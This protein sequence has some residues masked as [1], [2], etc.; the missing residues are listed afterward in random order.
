MTTLL[1]VGLIGAGP[2]TQAIHLPTL[3]TLSERL[4]VR[5]VMDVDDAVAHEVAG[6][7]GARASTDVQA[8][9][10]DAAVDVVGVCSPSPFHADQVTAA[11][12]AGKRAVFCEKPLATSADEA[13]RIANVA[14]DTGVPIVVGTMHAYDPAYVAAARL[15]D[16]QGHVAHLV[17]STIYLPA[18]DELVTL[19]TD[20]VAAPA[21]P[22]PHQD[23]ASREGRAARIRMA[24]LGLA[25]HTTPLVRRLLG[26][27]VAVADARVVMPLG[28]RLTLVSAGRSA[29]LVS[30]MPG[31][32]QPEWT[33]EAW[34]DRAVMRVWFPPSYVLAGSA[35]ADVADGLTH[36]GWQFPGNG[37]QAEWLRVADAAEGDMGAAAPIKD[38]VDDLRF[39]LAVADG[40]AR[41]IL[42]ER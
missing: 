27:D 29:Q 40:A 3:A 34:A 19:A 15:W 37:Y 26:S 1:G 32:W 21:S 8:V 35:R 33:L 24:V 5:H 20:L 4:Q 31:A 13:E 11:C 7:V 16:Q 14:R 25:I 18:N 36:A 10:E 22:R 42:E 2:A 28:Y 41:L 38:V 39:A 12:R 17:R 9:L 30:F 23:A 6:R